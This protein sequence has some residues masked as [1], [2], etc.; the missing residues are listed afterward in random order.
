MIST[1]ADGMVCLVA[2][3]FGT[4]QREPY[5]YREESLGVPLAA[6]GGASCT[7][8]TAQ[9]ATTTM[10]MIRR[11]TALPSSRVDGWTVT[12]A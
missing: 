11:D 3:V 5:W 7:S 10:P 1:D 8:A 6:L 2:C 4:G 9:I 12:A